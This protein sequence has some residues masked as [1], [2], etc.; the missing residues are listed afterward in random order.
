MAGAPENVVAVE[1]QKRADAEAK[2]AVLKESIAG[3]K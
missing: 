3:L 2:I 1:N